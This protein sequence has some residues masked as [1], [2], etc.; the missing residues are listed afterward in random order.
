MSKI[1][2]DKDRMVISQGEAYCAYENKC[3]TLNEKITIH[4]HTTNGFDYEEETSLG[5]IILNEILPQNM[6]IINRASL[7]NK[8]YLEHNY[9]FDEKRLKVCFDKY[10]ICSEQIPILM[11]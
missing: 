1:V 2:T 3:L 7:K 11:L 5:R 8:Y 9:E 6:G 10:M 4:C